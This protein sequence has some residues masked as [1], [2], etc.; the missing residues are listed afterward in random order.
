MYDEISE[1][2]L[3]SIM[4]YAKKIG[5]DFYCLKESDHSSPHWA[6]FFIYVLLG[7]YDRVLYLDID[8]II[9]PD[10]PDLFA[11]VPE[12]KIGMFNNLPLGNALA[13]TGVKIRN[14]LVQN[15]AKAYG[16]D[17]KLADYHYNS[18]VMV[19]P[20]KYKELFQPPE[21]EYPTDHDT[22]KSKVYDEGYINMMLALESE[23]NGNI[24]YELPHT[25]NR[26]CWQDTVLSEP[27]TDSYIIHYA[28]HAENNYYILQLLEKDMEE[29]NKKSWQH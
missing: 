4:D 22:L 20:K 8:L 13:A 11:L 28:C 1:R 5:A 27:R 15:V 2:T 24:M 7:K 16:K 14:E 26:M 25:F 19:I 18:G 17:V 9:R 3:P 21:K 6:K 10:C 23:K 29:W 12:D